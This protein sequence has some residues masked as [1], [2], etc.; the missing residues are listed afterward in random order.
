MSWKNM[1][2]KEVTIEM[3]TNIYEEEEDHI[4]NVNKCSYWP[5]TR[6]L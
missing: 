6:W 3:M 2:S 1:V 4:W 5:I